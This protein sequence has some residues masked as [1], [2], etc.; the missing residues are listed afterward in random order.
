VNSGW[1]LGEGETFFFNGVP[2]GSQ[3]WSSGWPGTQEYMDS[4]NGNQW[5]IKKERKN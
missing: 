4:T 1:L 2:P 3:L 5:A